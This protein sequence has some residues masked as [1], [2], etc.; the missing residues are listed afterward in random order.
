MKV[1]MDFVTNSSSSSFIIARKEELSE[2]LKEL[3]V[4]FVMENMMGKKMLEPNST[5]EQIQK[6]CD[7]KYICTEDEEEIRSALKEGKTVY[8]GRIDF[9]CCV[10]NY[11]DLFEELWRKLEETGKGEFVTI[12][13][14]LS[15]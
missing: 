11:A 13:G 6:L 12:D 3:I 9:E 1:R 14:D 10:D 2:Q 5:E 8:G 15:Y 7:E 4:E